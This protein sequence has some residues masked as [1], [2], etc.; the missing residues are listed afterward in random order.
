MKLSKKYL[1]ILQEELKNVTIPSEGNIPEDGMV[2][3]RPNLIHYAPNDSLKSIKKNGLYSEEILSKMIPEM[4]ERLCERYK[5]LIQ[6]KLGIKPDKINTNNF[7]HFL[8]MWHPGHTKCIYS[9]FNRIP[10]GIP[11][12]RQYLET[13]TPIRISLSKLKGSDIKHSIFGVNFPGK[14][15][16]VKLNSG[17]IKKLCDKNKDWYQYFAA[18]DEHGF[19]NKVPHASIYTHNGIIPPFTL[20]ILDDDF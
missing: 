1:N 2:I 20:K 13:H 14:K 15:K 4:K 16:W 3:Q 12:Y 11:N 5:P 8:N 10:E 19:F 17:H 9:F 6:S 7:L 18:E